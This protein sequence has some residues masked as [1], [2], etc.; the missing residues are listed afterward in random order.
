MQQLWDV[1]EREI[2]TM[3]VKLTHALLKVKSGPTQNYQDVPNKVM[4]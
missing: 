1:T 4:L 2:H 3:E